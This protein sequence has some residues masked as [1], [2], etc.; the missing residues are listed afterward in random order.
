MTKFGRK[1]G[2]IAALLYFI[3]SA[4]D[5]GYAVIQDCSWLSLQKGQ[6]Y[7][8]I[9]HSEIPCYLEHA[10]QHFKTSNDKLHFWVE[11]CFFTTP[12]DFHGNRLNY[13]CNV[14]LQAGPVTCRSLTADLVDFTS[15]CTIGLFW[16]TGL[17]FTDYRYIENILLDKR[18]CS[19][20]YK[21]LWDTT[22]SMYAA[23]RYLSMYGNNTLSFSDNKD[24][25]RI[26][27]N[28]NFSWTVG[29]IAVVIISVLFIIIG[30]ITLIVKI[31]KK[32]KNALT[33][34]SEDD[35]TI[36]QI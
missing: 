3:L 2:H 7:C 1:I 10:F 15:N 19:D 35:P 33:F 20:A 34:S 36:K 25:I 14:H 21:D 9:P 31:R 11:M 6:D 22:H 28:S 29:T 27:S 32:V 5:T 16:H 4:F 24:W 12:H 26:Y 18:N 17:R 13:S 8:Y 30:A 23:D